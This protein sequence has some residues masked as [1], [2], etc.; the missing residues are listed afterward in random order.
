[1]KKYIIWILSTLLL[2]L[3]FLYAES[4]SVILDK[5]VVNGKDHKNLDP[6]SFIF[7]TKDKIEIFYHLKSDAEQK[8]PFRFMVSLKFQ[9]QEYNQP[10]NT[11]SIIY[12][13]L[14]ES[15][16][17]LNIT[18]LDPRNMLNVIPLQFEF[19][20]NDR[21][22]E[23]LKQVEQSNAKAAKAESLLKEKNSIANP[24][25]N[26]LIIAVLGIL[27]GISIIILAVILMKKNI[28]Q[29]KNTNNNLN[30]NE[31]IFVFYD[32][33]NNQT[34]NKQIKNNGDNNM[35]IASPKTDLKALQQ[36]NAE[37]KQEVQ[38]L[39]Q[40]IE[41]LNLKSSELNK[42]N[43]ELREKSD[44]LAKFNAEL[45]ELQSH[46]D[47]LFAMV[48]HDIKNPA[49]LVKSLVEL[50]NSYDLSATEQKE[51]IEDI[52]TTTSKIVNLSQEVTKI[53][54]LESNTIALNFEMNDL[55][56][57]V[58][59]IAR[60]NSI[61]A[62]KKQ[63]EI[64]TELKQLPLIPIDAQKVDE[65]IDNLVSNAIKYS[66]KG[67]TVK[68]IVR[69]D[70]NYAEVNVKDNGLG[71]SQE[72]ISKA[73]QRG[74]RLSASPTANEHS[75]GFGLWIVKKLTEAHK[76]RIK[77]AS[78]LGKGSTFTAQFPMKRDDIVLP[79]EKIESENTEQTSE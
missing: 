25:N 14:Q 37:L 4:A 18:A 58:K 48:I 52:M 67:S 10:T 2:S 64:I 3:N 35:A 6:S 49:G 26:Y 34:G 65:I 78:S 68:I 8:V 79:E 17:N 32:S 15:N 28:K 22:L 45:T 40:Q 47:D 19:R 42:Q 38:A 71:L 53:L 13:N 43:V 55:S 57:I 27:L 51:I 33:N 72:D 75:S 56:E 54:S 77:I 16:Y 73:F 46:K 1:M 7:G 66:P 12:S 9:D 11:K 76:G 59:D 60:R 20:I 70:S 31:D 36:E 63:I 21:E 30:N 39:R 74:V 29:K 24:S 61:N 5:I 50:L 44:K 62:D 23:L 41:N 69:K